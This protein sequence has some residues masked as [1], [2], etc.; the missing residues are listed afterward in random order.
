MNKAEIV[1]GLIASRPRMPQAIICANDSMAAAACDELKAHGLRVPED[2]IVTGF[3]GTPTA[4]LVR[5]QLTTCNSNLGALADQVISLIRD[6]RAGNELPPVN[7][8]PYSPVIAESCGCAGSLHPRFNAFH[9]F[10]QAESMF[11]HENTTYYSVEQMLDMNDIHEILEQVSALLLPDSALYINQ[12][13]LESDPDA[14]YTMRHLEDNLIMIPYRAPDKPLVFRK[15]YMKDTGSESFR[16][17]NHQRRAFQQTGLRLLRRAFVGSDRRCPDDQASERRAEPGLFHPD[18][19]PPPAPADSAPRKQSV[20]GL[21]H[22]PGKPE[23]ADP[24]V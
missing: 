2:V 17:H 15:V 18:R 10:R 19:P 24:L 21:R 23:R 9:T 20:Y 1:R 11:N 5:P 22:R 8:H 3:D 13:L 6:F 7:T 16:G 14:E 12:S 4:Y